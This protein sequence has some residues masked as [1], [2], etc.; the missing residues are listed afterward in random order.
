MG[1]NF[2]EMVN[3]VIRDA[4]ILLMVLDARLPEL[5]QNEEIEEKVRK[6]NKPLIYVLNKCDLIS[7]EQAEKEKKI[8]KPCVFVSAT[9]FL[10]T[11]KL[12]ERIMI[13]ASRT[14][15][16]HVIVGVLGYPNT[17][18][19]SVINALKG[20]GKVR[21]SSIAGFTKGIQ[22]V[23]IS[24]KVKLLDTPGVIPFK[25][26]DE[27][28][29]VLIGTKMFDKITDPDIHAMGLIRYANGIIEQYYGIEKQK[30][31][32]TALELL[33]KKWKKFKK[34]A[35]PDLEGSARL[36][37][38]D[39][40]QGKIVMTKD[41]KESIFENDEDD[42]IAHSTNEIKQTKM[43]QKAVIIRGGLFLVLKRSP[44]ADFFPDY[45]DFPGGKL[46]PNEDLRTGIEREVFEETGLTINAEK[47]I[48]TYKMTLKDIPHQFT[49]YATKLLSPHEEVTLSREHTQSKWVTKEELLKLKIEP[50]M[51]EYFKEQR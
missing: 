19:S 16:E 50:Y 4:D 45:W 14:E 51:V 47:I 12:R 46:E 26:D 44:R 28:K 36:L 18:K 9:R 37:L 2:W 27:T 21:T 39:W 20:K 6:A 10:G 11:S 8:F 30:D 35:E 33:A 7:K 1:K 13:E 23:K 29:H 24:G 43:I 17:G 3:Q 34:G 5:T 48:G 41:E 31:A 49:V 15:K 25:E 32:E 42:E 38:K 22:K 40:Q